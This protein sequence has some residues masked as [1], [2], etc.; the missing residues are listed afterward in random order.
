MVSCICSAILFGFPISLT[1]SAGALLVITAAYIYGTK[2][3]QEVNVLVVNSGV[4]EYMSGEER[5]K[6]HTP[7]H[8]ITTEIQMV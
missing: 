8:V 2:P 3:Y 1:F 7:K 6:G 5:L 4:D